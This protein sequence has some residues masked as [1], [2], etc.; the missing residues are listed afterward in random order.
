MQYGDDVLRN[1]VSVFLFCLGTFLASRLFLELVG[2]AA[3]DFILPNLK[4]NTYVWQYT[5]FK[6]LDMWGAWDTGWLLSIVNDGYAQGPR[7]LN[8]QVN[9]AFFPAFPIAARYIAVITGLSPIAS[10][11]LLA[12]VCFII[13][14]Y[15]VWQETCVLYGDKAADICVL[16]FCFAPGTHFFSSAYTESMFLM[17]TMIALTCARKNN[18]IMAGV[19]AALATMTRNTGLLLLLPF[20]IYA[21]YLMNERES[22]GSI[23][24]RFLNFA[25]NNTKSFVCIGLSAL[26]PLAALGGHMMFLHYRTGDAL[27]FLNIQAAWGR[28]LVLPH[29]TLKNMFIH[30][31]HDTRFYFDSVYA[32][33]AILLCLVLLKNRNWPH[34]AF[35][36]ASILIFL[37]A[38]LGSVFRYTIGVAPF[39]MV[40][41]SI[42]VRY[43]R[44]FPVV[45]GMCAVASSGLMVGWVTGLPVF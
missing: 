12:N 9:W 28:V 30:I 10:M 21:I 44:V 45:L 24:E 31:G 38:G 4:S 17:F 34:A 6:W 37:S 11:V 23:S 20:A 19:A 16:L 15:A 8:E 27:A 5:S 7:P 3:Y 26:I 14:L 1:R 18:W 39:T 32:W 43:P 41:A 22:S 13:F 36:I 40:A 35:A 33:I 25:R 42:L 2:Y 29:V